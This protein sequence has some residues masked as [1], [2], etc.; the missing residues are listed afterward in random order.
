MERKQKRMGWYFLLTASILIIV[1]SFVPMF[2]ALITSFKDRTGTQWITTTGNPWYYNYQRMFQDK[3]FMTTLK[4]TYLYLIIQVPIMLVVAILLAQILNNKD[5]KLRGL[6]RTCIFLPCAISLVSYALIF[7]SLF[8]TEGL[9]NTILMGIGVIPSKVNWLGTTGT[10]RFVI[11]FAL[12]WRWTGYNMVFYLAGLQ[13]LD[14][15]VYEAARIDGANGWKTFWHITVPQLRPVII[16]TFIMSIN[17]TLQ[18]F[19]ESVNLTNGGPAGTTMTMSHYIYNNAFGTG[20]ANFG[21]AS[22]MSFLVFIMVAI[23]AIINLKVG[24]TRD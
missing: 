18:L 11:I 12:V 19:D 10:A 4:N 5:L 7:R 16:M 13:N 15:S 20:T 22:A 23:L 2:S 24:D 8:A 21:Y 6:F 3:M 17:G 1:F 9:V 14:Y